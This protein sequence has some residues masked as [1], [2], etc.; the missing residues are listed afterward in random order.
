MSLEPIRSVIIEDEEESLQLLQNLLLEKG[1]AVVVGSTT[2]PGKAIDML[3][4]LN[5]DIV[6]L[7]IRM[8]G[9]SGFEIL[10]DLG[11]IRSVN[12][13]IVFTTAYDE[14]A[15]KAFEYAA[16]DYLLKPIEPQRLAETILRCIDSKRSGNK[17][18]PD[19]LLSSYR[20]LQFRNISGIVFIDPAEIVYVEAEGNYSVFH[21]SNNKTETVTILLGKL[22][23]QLPVDNFFRISRSFI[24][25][26]NYLKKV[27]TRLC[28]CIL[29]K[30]GYEFK[31]DIS[32]DRISSL[33]E[34]MKNR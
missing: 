9:K 11:K 28:Q 32:H 21:L 1:L 31:C 33:V 19:V 34:K 2:E 17:Q 29:A 15:V 16:F 18:Q 22:E 5:P 30:N 13:Y 23:D 14:F 6:F 7:D 12:P 24:I 4:R 26:L 8:P 10:D 3:I 20:K 25:N 27:N